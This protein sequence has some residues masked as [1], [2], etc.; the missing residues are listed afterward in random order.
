VK[1]LRR[2]RQAK[3]EQL[4]SGSDVAPNIWS[5][6]SLFP[7]PVWD[8]TSVQR[9]LYQIKERDE[10]QKQRLAFQKNATD[11]INSNNIRQKK[12]PVV[13]STK[14]REKR[15]SLVNPKMRSPSYG[16]SSV[17]R[18]WREPKLSSLES[19][20]MESNRALPTRKNTIPNSISKT[21]SESIANVRP[22]EKLHNMSNVLT[23]TTSSNSN[24]KTKP[25]KV[26]AD[27]TRLV[28]DRIFGYR[29]TKTGQLQY[30]TSLMGDGAVQFR[31]GVRLSNPLRVN[32]DRLNYLAK[33]EL[34]HGRVE[35]AQEL[36]TIALQIDPRDGRAYLGM[37]RCAS[38][39]RD[40]K[41]AKVWLQTG[42]SN[43][44]SVNENTM[45]A[46]RGANPFLLQALGCLE[47]NSG[48]LSEAEALYIA[49]ARS[50]PTHAAAWV[51]L[52]QLRIRKLG[53]S[54]NAGRVC[55]QSAEREWQRASLPPSAHVYTAWAALE[56][57]ANDIRRAR[58]LYK[59]AL[60]V[61][62]RSS[63]AWLQLGVM[64]ADEENWNEAETCFETAL[65]FD[66][67][68]SRLLQAYALMETKRPNGNSR[69]A[70]GLLERALKANPRDAGVLQ[71]YALYVAELGDVDAARDLLRRGAEANKR[72][73]PVWQAWAVL[74]TRHG[75]VQEARSIFQEGI[76]ACA[77][78]T[79]GQSGGYRCARLWQAWGV[80]EAREGDAAAARRCFSRA[81]DA[82]SRNVA[83]VTAWALMEEEFGN[84]RDARAIYERSLR[85][86]AAGSGEK[87]SIWRNYELMEQR[88]G[89]VAA[90]Q[91]VYQRSMREAITVSD[92]IADN[93][94]GLSAKSTT[95]LP[96]LT[97]VLSRSSDE[98]EVLRWE[99]QSKS[100]LG[101]EV[102]L[103][104][105]AIEGKVPFD[106]KT[107][108]RRNKKTDKK[109]NQTP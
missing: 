31:D 95:P 77:Q 15:G 35:E 65:K 64:E 10:K 1:T 44:V 41:L 87:T 26:D 86:F 47:E 2:S 3:Y 69:K 39:R 80:L 20:S 12:D 51:S 100:S 67:R 97:N 11:G 54:A 48:R 73:A 50:R 32:A 23:M 19:P 89:H 105:R 36:Y 102:W 94:V 40:F 57:E 60:D 52:G 38:R 75:N 6:E 42:I 8:E 85:L 91:N 5:F 25:A 56:C 27:L 109:Y 29:R 13:D 84:V 16:G 107:N 68:N 96:D 93:I 45:Q 83:A 81:L 101:G 18:L 43:A 49:A 4:K 66:R 17:M 58:Q 30:D 70:I 33:K 78:L 108:Q 104:D 34:Q 7:D 22:N 76:W 72:H 82:D 55:F 24:N 53:Q 46:D 106:M 59:A 92:E 9:D 37:S 61:D 79:G 88:L 63:V 71:A 98:V 62:P 99:G 90:A 74:E 21:S 103:N 14:L 28:R